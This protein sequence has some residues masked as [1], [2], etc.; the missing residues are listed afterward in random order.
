MARSNVKVYDATGAEREVRPVDAK[1]IV[2]QGGSYDL[3]DMKK[4]QERENKVIIEGVTTGRADSIPHTPISPDSARESID[5]GV[6][7]DE[8]LED[9][10]T[11]PED[12][13]KKKAPAKPRK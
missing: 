8:A 9:E 5:Y 11:E 13:P 7:N 4:E 2:E 3:E 1:E 10:A 12:K 6:K